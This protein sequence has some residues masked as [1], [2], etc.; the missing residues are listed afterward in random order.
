VVKAEE[1]VGVYRVEKVT[2]VWVGRGGVVGGVVVRAAGVWGVVYKVRKCRAEPG[3][4]P[5]PPLQ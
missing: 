1:V 4:V 3:F 5:T 2:Q